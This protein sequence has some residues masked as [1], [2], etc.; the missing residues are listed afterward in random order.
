MLN[1]YLWAEGWQGNRTRR[2]WRSGLAVSD[3]GFYL[4][5]TTGKQEE[6]GP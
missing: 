4:V 1:K 3:V 5:N 2:D 6:L